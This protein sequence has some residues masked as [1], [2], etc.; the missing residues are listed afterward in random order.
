MTE[1]ARRPLSEGESKELLARYGVVV[2]PFAVVPDEQAAVRAAEDFGF[3]V[4]VKGHGEGLAHKTELDLVALNLA[5]AGQ[6]RNEAKRMLSSGAPGLT[7]VVISPMVRGRRE[8]VAGLFRDL[9]FGPVVMFGL[10]GV[11]AEALN[12]VVFRLAPVTEKEALSML[13]EL[14][15]VKLL[16]AF[17][18]EAATDRRALVRV[19]TGLSELAINRPDVA[20]VDVNPLLVGPDGSVSAVDA[21][22]VLDDAEKRAP[23]HPPVGLGELARFFHPKSIAVVGASNAF[24]KW[25][26]R[27]PANLIAGGFKGEIH[28]VN[29]RGG[30]MWG[31]IVHRD[32]RDIPG[33][34]D[35]AA[36]TVPAG[37]VMGLLDSFAQK[38][39][40]H[41]LLITSGF[42]ET[43]Q[44][45]RELE[46]LLVRRATELGIILFGPNTMGISN[47]HLNLRLLG[48]SVGGTAGDTALVSQS[49][50]MGVQL[51]EFAAN[52]GIGIRAFAGSG[53]EASVTV[54]D[55]MEGFEVDE[56]TRTVLLYLESVKNGRRFFES[57]RRVGLK[58]PVV[59][60]KGGRTEAGERAAASHTGALAANHRI[61]DA[62]CRQ[63]GVV[64]VDNPIEMLDVSAVFSGL[65]LPKG[66]RVAILT[67][68]GGWGVVTSDLCA[69]RRLTVAPLDDSV[70]AALDRLLPPYWSRANPVDLVGESDPELPIKALEL[71]AAW[72]GCD[73]VI[74]LGIYGRS[75]L[76]NASV[77]AVKIA[78][79]S[80]DPAMTGFYREFGERAER[81]YLEAVV[82]AIE[83]YGKPIIGVNL[84]SGNSTRTLFEV[85]GARYRGVFFNSPERAVN[86]LHHMCR[87]ADFA[88]AAL[89]GV[90]NPHPK[91]AALMI[92]L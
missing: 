67:L 19:I 81:A 69:D 34:V 10:G 6:V 30:K 49:G 72:E 70:L 26:Q 83:K 3:P 57:A 50:N 51:L 43:G 58:K 40:R 78:D 8:F 18:G 60:L 17:R 20:E 25:G 55:F 15:S 38:G 29:P 24:G 9:D 12:D 76:L 42:G 73:A 45:G 23:T 82:S 61:F 11:F 59:A 77:S 64:T 74:N 13:S 2:A 86:A 87:Y 16:D 63:A 27:L 28:F 41:L 39:I 53:N 54:E 85:E 75:H 7:G 68:G 5:T 84:V 62:A 46:R 22:V 56:L 21:L 79:P 92:P 44:E 80:F 4:A 52:Q 91:G 33:P 14:K 32:V 89:T 36:V 48:V 47:P 65:P 88:S 35:L 37:Q 71:L 90:R 31:R 1:A 66:R